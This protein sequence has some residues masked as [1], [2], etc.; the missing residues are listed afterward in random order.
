[1]HK[2]M[3]TITNIEYY[4][5]EKIKDTDFLWKFVS[6]DKFLSTIINQKLYFTRLDRFEDCLEGANPNLLL[7]NLL[8]KNILNTNAFKEIQQIH[9]IDLFPSKTDEL[10]EKLKEIQLFNFANCWF[11][12][13]KNVES[14]AMWNLYSSKN[15]VALNISYKNFIESIKKYNLKSRIVE[16]LTLGPIDYID[17]QNPEEIANQ[18]NNNWYNP[19]IKDKSFSH[20]NEFR[21]VAEIEKYEINPIKYKEGIS[22]YYQDEFHKKTSQIYGLDICFEE[23][24]NYNF[25]VVF[26]PKS[27]DWFK[28]DVNCLLSKLDIPFKT[29]DSNL[30]L[31]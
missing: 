10:I 26:H 12:S 6:L 21:L 19:F 1:M 31:K 25:E 29:R 13:S 27:E 15:S 7:L 8:R 18:K 5:Q 22:K 4:N 24:I 28:N 30:K 17:F 23:F 2:F 14:T 3:K 16:K 11:I 9:G 20:E